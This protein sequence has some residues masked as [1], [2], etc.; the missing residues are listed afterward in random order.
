M[1]SDSTP[2]KYTSLTPPTHKP[3]NMS[4]KPPPEDNPPAKPSTKFK[5]TTLGEFDVHVSTPVTET[6]QPEWPGK[7]RKRVQ[8][9]MR[10]YIRTPDT[11][12]IGKASSS[13]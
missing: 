6:S 8:L 1:P 12:G 13:R 10:F 9:D 11:P 7:E 5:Q 4:E 3:T 2:A